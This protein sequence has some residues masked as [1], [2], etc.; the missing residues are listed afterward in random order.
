VLEVL[1][2]APLTT[3]GEAVGGDLENLGDG[4]RNIGNVA[5][6]GDK[7]LDDFQNNTSE[8]RYKKERNKSCYSKR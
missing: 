2:L 5:V 8:V 6:L 1:V 3:I 7:A 4:S